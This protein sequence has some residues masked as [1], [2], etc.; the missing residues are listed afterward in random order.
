MDYDQQQARI[1][2]L[3]QE[4]PSEPDTLAFVESDEDEVDVVERQEDDSDTEQEL[5]ADENEQVLRQVYF[6]EGFLYYFAKDKTKWRSIHHQKIFE[7]EI[8]ISFHIYR[9]CK[10]S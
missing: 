2:Q 6:H 7:F 5:N 4:T 9:S 3:L 10:T 1:L 8:R